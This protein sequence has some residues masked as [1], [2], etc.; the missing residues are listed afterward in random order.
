MANIVAVDKDQ[1][2]DYI[3]QVADE[4]RVKTGAT[5]KLEFPWEMITTIRHIATPLTND[6]YMIYDAE[7]IDEIS[8]AYNTTVDLVSHCTQ[9]SY[10]LVLIGNTLVGQ[11]A[12]IGCMAVQTL[13]QGATDLSHYNYF[14]IDIYNSQVCNGGQFQINFISN[15]W[16]ED[17]YNHTFSIADWSVGWHKLIVPKSAIQA[18]TP[19]DWSKIQKIR[20]TYFNNGQVDNGVQFIIDNFMAY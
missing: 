19:S 11:I 1:L 9:G 15:D 5:K 14:V 6:I 12:N 17:G 2:E 20:Y 10:G 8:V 16:G 4:I 18:V 13:R 3:T 7:T